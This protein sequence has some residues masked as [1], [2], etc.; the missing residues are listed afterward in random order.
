[1]AVR[2]QEEPHGHQGILED[3]SEWRFGTVGPGGSSRQIA[4]GSNRAVS[5][6]VPC[7]GE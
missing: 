6:R 4:F 2:V 7:P 1:V 5:R 3:P